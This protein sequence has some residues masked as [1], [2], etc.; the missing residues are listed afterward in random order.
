[1]T[2]FIPAQKDTLSLA[3]GIL[4]ASIARIYP[5]IPVIQSRHQLTGVNDSDRTGRG[6]EARVF[7]FYQSQ[8]KYKLRVNR[9]PAPKVQQGS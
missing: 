8:G 2:V 4:A 3:G 7:C 1:M 9:N 6:G 5:C